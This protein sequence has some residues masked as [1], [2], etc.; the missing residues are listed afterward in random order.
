MR[1]VV[2]R[3]G[4][5]G[6][7]LPAPE[8]ARRLLA[9]HRPPGDRLARRLLGSAFGCPPAHLPAAIDVRD[10]PRLV[11]GPVADLLLDGL[12]L[13][14]VD[15]ETT[16]LSPESAAIVEIGA[17]RVVRGG[18]VDRFSTLIDPGRPIPR[19]VAELTGIHD[20]DVEDAPRLE[21][22]LRAFQD[23][24]GAA[25]PR[26]LVAHNAGFDERFVRRAW[27]DLALPRW[28]GP[29]F[30]TR[31]LAKRLL[32]DLGRYDLDTLAGH[33]GIRNAWRHRALGDA[34]A[35]ARALVEMI[36]IGA[37]RHGLRT[38]GDWLELQATPPRRLREALDRVRARRRQG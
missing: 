37:S 18:C 27:A 17:V 35:T 23:W 26:A 2:E 1:K 34:E 22:A 7:V 16:G 14:V 5:A 20:R 31:R 25:A 28:W 9:L 33:F 11:E 3:I 19:F 4:R 32:P 13:I 30:C 24:L 8:L 10:L 21:A 38:T 6:E 29:V 12:E 36:A 15:L